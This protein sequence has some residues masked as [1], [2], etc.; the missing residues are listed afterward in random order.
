[1]A[2]LTNF[3]GT[4]TLRGVKVDLVSDIG[5]GFV[6]DCV[7]HI[8]GLITSEQLRGKYQLNEDIWRSLGSNEQLQNAIDRR[9]ESRIR[10]GECARERAQHHFVNAPNI[11]NSIMNSDASPRHKVESI[12]EMRMIAANGPENT[13]PAADRFVIRINM[14]PDPG[15]T[16]VIDQPKKPIGPEH[17]EETPDNE[18]ERTV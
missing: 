6:T 14:G 17:A 15:D 8:E 1:M 5:T 4:V 12:R 9:K 3:D 11:L 18:H 16:I 7:R 10:S 2:E 13:A